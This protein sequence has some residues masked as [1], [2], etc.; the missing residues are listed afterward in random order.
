MMATVPAPKDRASIA[1]RVVASW[2]GGLSSPAASSARSSASAR[3][4]CFE[5]TG[6]LTRQLLADLGERR[7]HARVEVIDE[8]VDVFLVG[9]RKRSAD[10]H[11]DPAV[12]EGVNRLVDRS[13]VPEPIAHDVINRSFCPL[14]KELEPATHEGE[15][16]SVGRSMPFGVD[17]ESS[18]PICEVLRSLKQP[19]NLR[20]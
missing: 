8:L 13:C 5:L 4:G 3:G 17:D 9:C 1:A 10:D 18:F 2:P 7:S 19:C 14:Q 20:F 15:K 6:G 16:I 11:F 12:R